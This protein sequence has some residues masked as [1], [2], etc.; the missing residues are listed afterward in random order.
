MMKPAYYLILLIVLLGGCSS[1]IQGWEI[2]AAERICSNHE[3]VD[4]LFTF[5]GTDVRCG[6]GFY[7][8][9]THRDGV[10]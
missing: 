5:L 4:H 9:I 8:S 1:V 6:D 3:G 7:S 2:I 10:K